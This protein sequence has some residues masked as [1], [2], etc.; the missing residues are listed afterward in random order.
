MRSNT[1]VTLST[2]LFVL[3]VAFVRIGFS[4]RVRAQNQ[5]LEQRVAEIKE[6]AAKNK[7]SLTQYTWNELVIISLK[8]EEK[9]QSTSRCA[10]ARMESR[11]RLR[12]TRPRIL[13][14][15]VDG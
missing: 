12:F 14:K 5:D 13:P 2:K 10:S 11:K 3:A 1:P 8:G 4:S 9:K 7:Q 15:A 6:A